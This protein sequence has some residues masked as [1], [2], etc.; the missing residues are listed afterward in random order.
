MEG[1]TK[2]NFWNDIQK[3]YPDQVQRFKDWIDNFK[4]TVQWE[5]FKDGVKFHNLHLELQYGILLRFVRDQNVQIEAV[6][7]D[8]E[9]VAEM[10]RLVFSYMTVRKHT[11][12]LQE[13]GGIDPDQL[14]DL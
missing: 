10:M 7:F 5:P 8:I 12:D 13:Y 1:L 6:P 3:D 9:E 14:K 11:E 2:E 4:R